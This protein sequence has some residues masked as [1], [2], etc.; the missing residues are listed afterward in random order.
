V[1]LAAIWFQ[2]VVQSK[3]AQRSADEGHPSPSCVLRVLSWHR[4]DDARDKPRTFYWSNLR[5]LW[6][7]NLGLNTCEAIPSIRMQEDLHRWI[8]RALHWAWLG[9]VLL[10]RRWEIQW[11]KFDKTFQAV[12]FVSN[13]RPYMQQAPC[14]TLFRGKVKIKFKGLSNA[15]FSTPLGPLAVLLYLSRDFA[16]SGFAFHFEW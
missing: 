10:H 14:K 8:R 12:H 13:K 2:V 1:F 15:T 4:C 3:G 16:K 5:E 6:K 7:H 9:N 11:A